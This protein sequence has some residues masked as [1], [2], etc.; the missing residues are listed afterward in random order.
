MGNSSLISNGPSRAILTV[1]VCSYN[2]SFYLK[3]CLGAL[4][5][6][7]MSKE[8]YEI[9]VIDNNSIDDTPEIV[10]QYS[11][12][13]ENVRYFR[14]TRQGLSYARN[15]GLA[16]VHTDWVAYV[17]DDGEVFP[18][19]I[20]VVLETIR[21]KEYDAF[22][23]VYFPKYSPGKPKWFRDDF[24]SNSLISRIPCSIPSG[25]FWF[26]GGICAFRRSALELVGGFPVNLGMTGQKLAYGEETLVQVRLHRAGYKLGFV[27]SIRMDHWVLPAKYRLWHFATSAFGEG[28]DSWRSHDLAPRWRPLL[29]IYGSAAKR[30]L[31]AVPRFAIAWVPGT[32][33]RAGSCLAEI[34]MAIGN[35]VGSTKGFMAARRLSGG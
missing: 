14:E 30:C 9:L 22:G 3:H 13:H 20:Q 2:R 24:A 12:A 19:F 16:E 5:K 6:Q 34:L 17:D 28:R 26:C 11:Q 23:G 15:S 33:W 31:I 18:D 27:P 35:A 29:R 4:L 7:T 32:A 8:V 10:A 25:P 21:S 1:V